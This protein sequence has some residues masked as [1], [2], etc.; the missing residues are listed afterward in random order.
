MKHNFIK[1]LNYIKSHPD[2]TIFIGVDGR[3]GSGKSTFSA[4]LKKELNS[5][6]IKAEIVGT[7]NFYKKIESDSYKKTNISGYNYGYYWQKIKDE[8]LI[9]LSQGQK[10]EYELKHWQSGLKIASRVL[11]P[12]Q[13]IIL[14]GVTSTYKKLAELIHIKIWLDCDESI[15]LERIKKR[16]D[17]PE[18]EL[19]D[20][21]IIENDYVKTQL[22]PKNYDLIID[23]S[24]T[25]TGQSIDS[26]KVLDLAG[27]LLN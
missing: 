13:L 5:K 1:I 15:R 27:V 12:N 20:W 23:T 25:L 19:Q 2:K 10:V 8:V 18:D 26:Y 11:E 17:F 7:D 9:P 6:G 4:V 14:E 21:T 3:S 22:E 24:A 16:G